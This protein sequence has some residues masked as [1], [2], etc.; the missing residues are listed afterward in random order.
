[1]SCFLN[2]SDILMLIQKHA[3]SE[4]ER[5]QDAILITDVF[6]LGI[7]ATWGATIDTD[8]HSGLACAMTAQIM[9]LRHDVVLEPDSIPKFLVCSAPLKCLEKLVT[10]TSLQALIAMVRPPSPAHTKFNPVSA[11]ALL[12]LL[13]LTAAIRLQG[14]TRPIPSHPGRD[15]LRRAVTEPAPGSRHPGRVP[16]PR[17]HDPGQARLLGSFLRR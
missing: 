8:E 4:R 11:P 2:K 6:L 1:M 3:C 17:Q 7:M 14:R 12:I 9:D 5:D 13:P 15:R 16:G 10:Y